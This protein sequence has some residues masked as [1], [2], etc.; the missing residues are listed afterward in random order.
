MNSTISFQTKKLEEFYYNTRQCSCLLNIKEFIEKFHLAIIN[1]EPIEMF[2]V[3]ITY[4]GDTQNYAAQFNRD[5]LI[6]AQLIFSKIKAY[7]QTNK[8]K[9]SKE[10]KIEIFSLWFYWLALSNSE[11]WTIYNDS[12][13]E[14]DKI[15]I[16]NYSFKALHGFAR[17]ILFELESLSCCYNYVYFD[18]YNFIMDEYDLG[19]YFKYD[20]F[21]SLFFHP[22]VLSRAICSQSVENVQLLL[23]NG[24]DL[25]KFQKFKTFPF[26]KFKSPLHWAFYCNNIEIFHLL[27]KNGCT[28]DHDDIFYDFNHKK[29]FKFSLY[30]HFLRENNFNIL[31]ELKFAPGQFMTSFKLYEHFETNEEIIEIL[32]SLLKI[33]LSLNTINHNF[34]YETIDK[35]RHFIEL[36]SCI[37][38]NGINSVI[39]KFL[40][41]ATKKQKNYSSLKQLDFEISIILKD[42]LSIFEYHLEEDASKPNKIHI[43]DLVQI[44]SSLLPLVDRKEAL[45]KEIPGYFCSKILYFK[46]FA[47]NSFLNTL[48]DE[49]Y[50]K[51]FEGGFVS[52]NLY[53]RNSFKLVECLLLNKFISHK[54]FIYFLISLLLLNENFVSFQQKLQHLTYLLLFS[55]ENKFLKAANFLDFVKE[56]NTI[57]GNEI[58]KSK[59]EIIKSLLEKI[60]KFYAKNS[61]SL[62]NITREAIRSFDGELHI[63]KHL[64][65]FINDSIKPDYNYIKALVV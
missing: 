32:E 52:S 14:D 4:C 29:N 9:M 61:F 44:Y 39:I 63:P 47:T 64:E 16:S 8:Y 42:I 11:A 56:L 51:L 17:E 43:N 40:L 18:N 57:L 6:Q 1:N 36:F 37:N 20:Q 38:Q 19:K 50:L 21:E 59:F 5:E 53:K 30:L 58:E 54:C 13:E 45:F 62:M 27:I 7:L 2:K 10:R 60:S 22:N 46:E 23:N 25:K 12:L 49:A 28:I 55:L 26:K 65:S 24:L 34:Y 41:N 31:N 33:G 35:P 3:G 15:D 48:R